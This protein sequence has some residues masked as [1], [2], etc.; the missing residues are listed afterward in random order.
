[1][2][3]KRNEKIDEESNIKRKKRI[4]T[5]RTEEQKIDYL[6]SKIIK[7]AKDYIK[8]CK[9]YEKSL[10][11]LELATLRIRGN[12][13][14]KIN[15]LSILYKYVQN[16][17]FN[18][19]INNLKLKES[20]FSITNI[21][22]NEFFPPLS[23]SSSSS[24]SNKR[25]FLKE[26]IKRVLYW[27]LW[28]DFKRIRDS[29]FTK[30]ELKKLGHYKSKDDIIDLFIHTLFK[31]P[32]PFQ[33]RTI[34]LENIKNVPQ[35]ENIWFTLNNVNIPNDIMK[36]IF[37]FIPHYNNYGLTGII[38]CL[39]SNFYYGF[40]NTFDILNVNCRNIK[41]IPLLVLKTTK[42]LVFRDPFNQISI[43]SLK[44]MFSNLKNATKF[45]FLLK[46]TDKFI[47]II[48]SGKIKPIIKCTCLNISPYYLL[49]FKNKSGSR[50]HCF[51]FPKMKYFP[52]LKQMIL[53]PSG[54]TIYY[55]G[56]ALMNNLNKINKKSVKVKYLYISSTNKIKNAY[57]YSYNENS[58][59]VNNECCFTMVE[60]ICIENDSFQYIQKCILQKANWKQIT[61]YHSYRTKEFDYP[62]VIDH[63]LT[64]CFKLETL[65]IH[66]RI[67][68]F[69]HCDVFRCLEIIRERIEKITL[70][71]I[72][73]F[74]CYKKKYEPVGNY[75]FIISCIK[76]LYD[77]CSILKDYH[78]KMEIIFK[79]ENNNSN[80][81][82]ALRIKESIMEILKNNHYK[83]DWNI[84]CD[85]YSFF[86]KTIV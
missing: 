32:T 81:N 34:E 1:M 57:K 56:K 37:S 85:L 60:H 16:K 28:K 14:E 41:D 3:R 8:E 75:K 17:Y 26:R 36:I 77:L 79:F 62:C 48:N 49:N 42:E 53:N 51:E 27:I 67:M 46:N 74:I 47:K 71:S 82:N 4:K 19:K 12:S 73:F 10:S 5:N 58:N 13:L 25:Y 54:N 39:N 66:L 22:Y 45:T 78:I 72:K 69:F 70:S 31:T 9:I 38:C 44:N 86:L 50:R 59:F 80:N 15:E 24:N 76:E 23:I 11:I 64:D 40:L 21:N 68:H 33:K 83:N 18:K 52:N 20:E 55:F 29:C 43:R 7:Y 6:K 61:I 65:N 84:D 2:K 63:I 30:S 35:M